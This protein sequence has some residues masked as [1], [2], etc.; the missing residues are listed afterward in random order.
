MIREV[1]SQ[2]DED[3]TTTHVG[4]KGILE[5]T[6]QDAGRRGCC[7]AP[8]QTNHRTRRSVCHLEV[9]HHVPHAVAGLGGDEVEVEAFG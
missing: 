2:Y 8:S 6:L 4:V 5:G 1:F 9:G 3:V 7:P